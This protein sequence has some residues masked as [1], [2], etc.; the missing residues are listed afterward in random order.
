MAARELTHRLASLQHTAP[1]PQR[2]RAGNARLCAD[3]AQRG[4]IESDG[5]TVLVPIQRRAAAAK[6]GNLLAHVAPVSQII[7][8]H[9]TVAG[10]AVVRARPSQLSRGR[11]Q[12]VARHRR[13]WR[14][15]SRHERAVGPV[16]IVQHQRARRAGVAQLQHRRPL[17]ALPRQRVTPQRRSP[18]RRRAEGA[19]RGRRPQQP[20]RE[21][22]VPARVEPAPP[23]RLGR[24]APARARILLRL[25]HGIRVAVRAEEE[26]VDHGLAR[27]EEQRR[28]TVRDEVGRRH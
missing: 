18:Q 21:R 14:H 8:G 11:V 23:P 24:P 9:G 17:R 16:A 20:Q 6:A 4:P 2:A 3:A 22:A 15:L 26:R 5:R 13:A 7:G 28:R 12:Q 10:R 19:E 1:V 25:V 27:V